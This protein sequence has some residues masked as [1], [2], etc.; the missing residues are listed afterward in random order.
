MPRTVSEITEI[1][2][3]RK[4]SDETEY[5]LLKRNHTEKYPGIW[6]VAGGKVNEN[7]KAFE[8]A[9]REMKEETGLVPLKLFVTECVNT[10]Y[11]HQTDMV[12]IV[13]VFLAE[14]GSGEVVLSEEHSGYEWMT[15]GKAFETLHWNSWKENLN[16]INM[17]LNGEG[18]GKM[19]QEIRL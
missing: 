11:E 5:L 17:V 3:Y 6:S 18:S 10:F 12:Q 4:I 14:A 9:I 15:F 8:A 16:F 13:P 1:F 7:E 2:I 19:L